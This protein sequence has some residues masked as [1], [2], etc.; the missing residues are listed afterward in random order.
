LQ[1]IVVLD[2]KIETVPS[3]IWLD[4]WIASQTCGKCHVFF[5]RLPQSEALQLM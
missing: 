3:F 1:V 5:Q 2:R 4:W